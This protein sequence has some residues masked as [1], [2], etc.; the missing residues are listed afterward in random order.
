MRK[1]ATKTKEA[2][3]YEY[4]RD[5][6]G[7]DQ[8]QPGDMLPTEAEIGQKLDINRM[9]ISKALASLKNEGFVERRAGRGTTLLR[10]PTSSSSEMILV[11]SPWPSWDIKDE[12]YFSRLL[13]AVQTKAIQS[14]LATVNLAIHAETAQQ[15]DFAKIRDIYTAVECRGAIV[16]DPYLATQGHLQT[17]LHDLNCRSVWAGATPHQADNAYTIDTDDYQASF[18]LTK[19]LIEAGSARP[20]YIGFQINTTARK[21]RLQ[22]YKDALKEARIAPD[23][24]YIICNGIPASLKEAGSECAGIY[25]ARGLNADS[26][27]LSD[28]LMIEGINSFC[29]QVQIPILKQLSAMPVA[30][31]DYEGNRQFPNIRF[32]SI[33]P[34]ELIGEEA[35]NMLISNSALPVKLIPTEILSFK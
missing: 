18:N 30:T 31:F 25:A 11:I 8:Y 19:K 28:F 14:G 7:S 4:L 32:S 35:V 22:G 26:Y 29:S 21:K 34:V 17:F 33:Q 10:K 5:L 2:I 24:R 12:W 1:T 15:D 16:V 3:A 27:V 9:T 13:Y 20:A 6:I 23:D